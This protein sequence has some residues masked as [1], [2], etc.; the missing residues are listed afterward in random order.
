MAIVGFMEEA[1]SAAGRTFIPTADA[2]VFGQDD[3]TA[4][5]F[6]AWPKT[7]QAGECLDACLAILAVASS[8]A[9]YVTGRR[10][11]PAGVSG[12]LEDVRALVPP[13]EEDRVLGSELQQ[14]AAHLTGT[15]LAED[16]FQERLS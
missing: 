15:V 13:V 1:R 10:G 16:S 11:V 3:V 9:L 2:S 8:Q 14:L 7:I 6:L 5:A 12:L 4:P